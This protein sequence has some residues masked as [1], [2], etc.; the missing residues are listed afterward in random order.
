MSKPLFPPVFA[1]AVSHPLVDDFAL[2]AARMRA[3]QQPPGIG[4][5]Y[6]LPQ[7]QSPI[8]GGNNEI[9]NQVDFAADAN[10]RQMVLKMEEWGEPGV[11]TTM[12]G[13]TYTPI[14]LPGLGF[15]NVVGEIVAGVGGAYQEFEVDWVE[16]TTFSCPL[17]ALTVTAKYEQIGGTTLQVPPDL[18]LR[19]TVGRKPLTN[20]AAPTRTIVSPVATSALGFSPAVIIPKFARRMS[21]IAT[22]SGGGVS[23][24]TPYIAGASYAWQ[25]NPSAP[26][27]IGVFSG[28]D[29]LTGFGANGIPIPPAARAVVLLNSTGGDIRVA[30]C[31]H[32]AL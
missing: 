25:S 22:F 11:W 1:P 12:L 16:G 13:L 26:S 15:F 20:S 3:R 24:S 9:G 28:A 6:A 31:F 7:R 10:N 17:N 4:S 8:W 29:F 21:P 18:R 5:V 27:T 14:N 23:G 32:L 2:R 30:Y 19:A